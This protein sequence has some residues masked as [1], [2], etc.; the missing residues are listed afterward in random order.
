KPYHHL[1]P[2]RQGPQ[3]GKSHGGWWR[4]QDGIGS[5]LSR[6]RA[7]SDV[8]RAL[9]ADQAGL[10]QIRDVRFGTGAT[11]TR[12]GRL[13]AERYGRYFFLLWRP[14]SS[15]EALHLWLRSAP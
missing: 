9:T 1:H 8:W 13:C 5:S 2:Y 10:Q 12:F 7:A 11:L 6:T 14:G 15:F 4:E 3:D